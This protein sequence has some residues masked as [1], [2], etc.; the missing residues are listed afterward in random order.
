[1]YPHTARTRTLGR[2]LPAG[3]QVARRLFGGRQSAALPDWTFCAVQ[4]LGKA[5]TWCPQV[6]FLVAG[7]KG[8]V[9]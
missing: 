9:P 3:G 6:V 1:M 2:L 8:H 5:A 4:R 7:T